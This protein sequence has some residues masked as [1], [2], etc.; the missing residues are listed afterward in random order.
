MEVE[1]DGFVIVGHSKSD[2]SRMKDT[3][4]EE[5]KQG[6]SD[7]N[8]RTDKVTASNNSFDSYLEGVPFTVGSRLK[9]LVV[10]KREMGLELSSDT[11]FLTHAIYVSE[12]DVIKETAYPQPLGMRGNHESLR[13]CKAKRRQ[14]VHSVI[15]F[16]SQYG[17]ENRIS[18]TAVNLVGKPAKFP[19]YGDF[20]ETYAPQSYGPWKSMRPS[21]L[22]SC[23][24]VK[25]KRDKKHLPADDFVDVK[26]EQEVYGETLIALETFNPGAIHRVWALRSQRWYKVWERRSMEVIP[27]ARSRSHSLKLRRIPVPACTYRIELYTRHLNYSPQID[28]IMLIGEDPRVQ[29]MET[30][31]KTTVHIVNLLKEFN[32]MSVV[33]KS[34]EHMQ[35]DFSHLLE[36]INHSPSPDDTLA[37]SKREYEKGILFEEE[38]SPICHFDRLPDEVIH[39]ILSFLDLQS[40]S[41][42]ARVSKA[43]DRHTQDPLLYTHI[44][45]DAVWPWTDDRVLRHLSSRCLCLQALDLSWCGDH[46]KVTAAEFCSF[47]KTCGEKL[48]GLWLANCRFLDEECLRAI[49]ETSANLKGE[50]DL[51]G[52]KSLHS[53]EMHWL[54]RLRS[55]EHLTLSDTRIQLDTLLDVVHFNPG[56][57]HLHVGSCSQLN[58]LDHLAVVLPVLTPYLSS[59]N[60]W[61]AQGLTGVGIT[62]LSRCQNL[63]ELEIGWCQEIGVNNGGCLASLAQGCPGLVHLGLSAVR[64]VS[65]ADL[66]AVASHARR[67]E[68]LELLGNRNLSDNRRRETKA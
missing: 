62:A 39:V 4:A 59:L 49:G 60:A 8:V 43:L 33:S 50:L 15:N 29:E 68:Q 18:Y 5:W 19:S 30:S 10:N 28:A 51:S 46:G 12:H 67:L 17:S 11:S 32:M 52:V 38:T 23:K 3:L 65:N 16:S 37:A 63:Q 58:P 25:R 9:H 2:P 31:S 22:H 56:I 36:D 20:P 48:Q 45:L 64:A 7:E 14:F 35:E 21:A 24:N 54:S 55:L 61:R 26:Y 6:L 42:I 41:S 47:I 34:P 66:A 57:R 44:H 27:V 53:L 40:L 1:E 13:E